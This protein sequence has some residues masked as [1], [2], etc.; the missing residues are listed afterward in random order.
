MNDIFN[1]FEPIKDIEEKI[2]KLKNITDEKTMELLYEKLNNLK[3][4]IKNHHDESLINNDPKIFINAVNEEVKKIN[5]ELIK[6][7][8]EI[9]LKNEI[10]KDKQATIDN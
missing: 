6:K 7:E 10:L 9:N 8:N 4:T 1:N 5:E 2:N 3:K